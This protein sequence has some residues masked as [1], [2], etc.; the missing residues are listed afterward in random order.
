M[1]DQRTD[2]RST[3]AAQIR[4]GGPISIATYMGLCLTHPHKGYYRKADPLG[5]AGDFVTAPEIS[6]M[7]GELIG[8]WAVN[9]WAQMGG[10]ERFSLLELG[11]GRGTLMADLLLVA[12]RTPGFSAA[13]DLRLHD[14]SEVL[15]AEQHRRL[16]R[17]A[18]KWIEDFDELPDQPV[19][20]IA[21]EFFDA[22][23]IRQFVRADGRWH[24]RCVGLKDGGL[25]FG[26]S[27]T[28]MPETAFPESV[29]TAR[30]G[31]L[32]ELGLAAIETMSRLASAIAPR[33]GAVL[34]ID[35]GYPA[36]G[37]GETLQA[38]ARHAFADPLAAPGDADLSAH[39]DFEAL[40]A[41]ARNAGLD[42]PAIV[43]QGEFL[44]AMGIHERAEVL[45]SANPE[46]AEAIASS[47]NRLT[48][49]DQ[50]GS[51][52]KVFAAVSP[53]LRPPGFGA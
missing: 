30:D 36:T 38:V 28:P 49:A 47:L 6:Q 15:K 4:I 51:L 13:L 9:L 18:P 5:V 19:I 16:A 27:P 21:N 22:L 53:G 43:T 42:V 14:A 20:V 23:P 45:S 33:G 8:V 3:I 40:G 24:E 2:L 41:A 50:M 7:F 46:D 32:Y 1:P 37:T 12:G 31:E 11:P 10:P 35:Y 44:D 25:A 34:A 26:L 39:V 29:R 17:H 52:F 48:A